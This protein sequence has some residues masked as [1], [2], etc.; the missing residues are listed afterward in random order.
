MQSIEL[1]HLGGRQ[2]DEVRGIEP[3]RRRLGLHS[4]REPVENALIESFNGRLRDECPNVYAFESLAHAPRSSALE[5]D[6]QA[7]ALASIA[8]ASLV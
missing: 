1:V 5:A 6:V 4:P 8:N 3:T 2:G 7:N